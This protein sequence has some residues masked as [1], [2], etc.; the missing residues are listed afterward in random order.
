[1][2]SEAK[3]IGRPRSFKAGK[4]TGSAFY[5]LKIKLTKLTVGFPGRWH[6]DVLN[7]L[8]LMKYAL[9][10][11]GITSPDGKYASLFGITDACG[12]LLRW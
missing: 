3:F 9:R 5:Q 2:G 11:N 1:M 12:L 10:L 7:D 6:V 4:Q 8:Q